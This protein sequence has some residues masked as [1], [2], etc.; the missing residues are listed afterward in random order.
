VPYRAV[1]H[2]GGKTLFLLTRSYRHQSLPSVP[3]H[4]YIQP[5]RPIAIAKWDYTNPEGLLE[6]YELGRQDARRFLQSPLP[7]RP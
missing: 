6:T 1:A 4:A 3:E 2:I 7:R 5:S